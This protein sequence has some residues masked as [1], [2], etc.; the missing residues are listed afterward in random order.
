VGLWERNKVVISWTCLF[1][2]GVEFTADKFGGG[3]KSNDYLNQLG[4]C[5]ETISDSWSVKLYRT[6]TIELDKSSFYTQ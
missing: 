4:F 2:N 3:P 5:I 6:A 1:T